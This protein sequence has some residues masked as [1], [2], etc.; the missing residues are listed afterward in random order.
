MSWLIHFLK[1]RLIRYFA[2]NICPSRFSLSSEEAKNNDF[3]EVRIYVPDGENSEIALIPKRNRGALTVLFEFIPEKPTSPRKGY[4]KGI[5]K[6]REDADFSGFYLS[7]EFIRFA[8]I[9]VY[10]YYGYWNVR[11]DNCSLFMLVK[12][13]LLRSIRLIYIEIF[14]HKILRYFRNRRIS[15]RLRFPLRSKF[16]IYE[17]LM[18]SDSYLRRG[19]FKKS[20][21]SSLV[22]GKHSS[23]EFKIFQKVSQSLDWVLEACIEDEEIE[24]ISDSSSDD[25]LYRVK[26]KGIHYFTL[27]KENIKR[28]EENKI[29][30]KQQIKIQNRMLLLTFLLVIGT[31]LAGIDKVDHL[32]N[33]YEKLV[34]YG[35]ELFE[36][37]Y[38]IA[39]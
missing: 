35:S 37:V 3:Y 29:I 22:F 2:K 32:I 28:E 34:G 11:E 31:F 25:Q 23:G 30:Q 36:L 16:E 20:E 6:K 33:L 18:A 13:F 4:I 17:A 5:A 27:T 24:R 9:D 1:I 21:L 39:T 10:Y 26:G 38:E 8:R 14:I 7:D 19:T 12:L 15:K